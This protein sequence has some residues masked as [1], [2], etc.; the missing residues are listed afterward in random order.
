MQ[1]F[2][3]EE[4]DKLRKR[5]NKMFILVTVQLENSSQSISNTEFETTDMALKNENRIDKLD[6]KID[7]LCQ[8][9]FALAQPVATDLR[10]IMSSLRIANEIE[11]IGDIAFDVIGRSETVRPYQET[12]SEYQVTGIFAEVISASRQ[13]TEAYTNNNSEL[14]KDIMQQCRKIEESCK[15]VF[16]EVIAKMTE[17]SQVILIAT[18]LILILRDLE[19][20]TNHLA[21]IAD[22]IVFIA[23]GKRL[24][25]SGVAKKDE[26]QGAREA[27]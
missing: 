3:Q 22:S 26:E 13:A 5:L 10:F 25:H 16:N 27:E 12:L 14:A 9:I 7:K 15:V 6:I 17:K 8:R 18:D 24:R 19:R 20:I 11:Q 4:L 23:E 21:T 1:P 2:F